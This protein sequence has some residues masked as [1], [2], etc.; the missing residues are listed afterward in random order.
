MYESCKIYGPYTRKDGRQHVIV[1]DEQGTKR[2]V[3]YPKFVM[4]NYLGR[5]LSKNETVDHIDTDFTN[6]DIDN[7]RV[8]KRS[9]HV[10][11]DVK[12]YKEQDFKCPECGKVF[13]LSGRKLHNA[14]HNRKQGKTGPFCGRPCAGRYGRKVQDGMT[15]IGI[16]KITPEYTTTKTSRSLHKETYEVETAKTGKP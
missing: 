9:Q 13:S 1:I 4:E 2:T 7:M 3:S 14:I 16:G 11:E 10:S 5:Y 12:R 6:N 8:I 15:P